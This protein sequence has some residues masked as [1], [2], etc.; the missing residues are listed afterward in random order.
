MFEAAVIKQ[1]HIISNKFQ[2][3]ISAIPKI[4]KTKIVIKCKIIIFKI[5]QAKELKKVKKKKFFTNWKILHKKRK[6]V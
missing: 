5:K 4:D 3:I 2:T 1:Q 6:K